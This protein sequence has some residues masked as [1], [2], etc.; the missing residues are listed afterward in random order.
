MLFPSIVISADEACPTLRYRP[1]PS[2][3]PQQGA[4]S[5][6]LQGLPF[7]RSLAEA[8]FLH[9]RRRIR[10]GN[11]D[12]DAEAVSPAAQAVHRQVAITSSQARVWCYETET[13]RAIRRSNTPP[14]HS[15]S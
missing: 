14:G 1:Y 8:Y 12:Y 4:L 6:A 7:Y 9:L 10:P 11:V 5:R 3:S 15:S 13:K 2:P